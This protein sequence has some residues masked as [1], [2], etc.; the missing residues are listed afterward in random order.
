[1][2]RYPLPFTYVSSNPHPKFVSVVLAAGPLAV[3]LGEAGTFAILAK[4]GV[5]VIPPSLI[6]G[7]VG[8][9]PAASTFLTGF[10]IT[11]DS[12]GTFGNSTQVSGQLFAADYAAPTPAQLTTAVG[13][14]ETAF[15]DA[16]GRPGPDFIN[17]ADGDIGGL[18]L[19]PGLYKWTS[20]VSI[21]SSV[22][23]SGNSTDTWIFQI[24]GDLTSAVNTDINLL[25][26]VGGVP[27]NNI[28]WVVSGAVTL[29]ATSHLEGILL[30]ATSATLETGATMNGRLLVQTAAA[31]QK[32]N[33]GV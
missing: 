25:G 7:N 12:T 13:D 26:G 14:M 17:L 29:G 9:S 8:L 10:S 28:V 15:T 30:G 2:F 19:T 16:S 6:N 21:S 18:T 4:A 24:S 3:S 1:M 31:V 33:V 5:S 11:E 20:D 32:G 27:M 23:L 22:T